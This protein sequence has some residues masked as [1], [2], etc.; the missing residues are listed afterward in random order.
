MTSGALIITAN[1]AGTVLDLRGG[2]LQH[3]N[4]YGTLDATNTVTITNT[5]N[6]WAS[7]TNPNN[8][9]TIKAAIGGAGKA[10]LDD[11]GPWNG[12]S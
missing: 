9:F 10:V 7:G 6:I 4:N 5:V 3:S 8:P 1:P 2:T 11:Y 12:T